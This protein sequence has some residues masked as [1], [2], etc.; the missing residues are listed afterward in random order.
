MARLVFWSGVTSLLGAEQQPRR[1]TQPWVRLQ[2]TRARSG[3]ARISWSVK[4]SAWPTVYLTA[5]CLFLNSPELRRP[6]VKGL[7]G[8]AL[9]G[10]AAEAVGI[11]LACVGPWAPSPDQWVRTTVGLSENQTGAFLIK[12]ELA[13]ISQVRRLS[14][15]SPFVSVKEYLVLVWYL[16]CLICKPIV[17]HCRFKGAKTLWEQLQN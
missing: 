7:I 4:V 14:P 17:V 3:L 15:S 10:R 9:W 11:H 16:R 1:G 12:P 13:T 8:L 5:P 2:V 6:S